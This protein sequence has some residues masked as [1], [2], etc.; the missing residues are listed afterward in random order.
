MPSPT[1]A[2]SVGSNADVFRNIIDYRLDKKKE[3]LDYLMAQEALR[4]D[5]AIIKQQWELLRVQYQRLT[6]MDKDLTD[7]RQGIQSSAA[8][9]LK[10]I[11][12][13]NAQIGA[14]NVRASSEEE[15]LRV[16]AIIDIDKTIEDRD[17]EGRSAVDPLL[18]KAVE[19]GN[20]FVASPGA[21][22]PA[23][24]A[25][26]RLLWDTD[27]ASKYNA[28]KDPVA[29]ARFQKSWYDHVAQMKA[30]AAVNNPGVLS[31]GR[32]TVQDARDAS[33]LPYIDEGTIAE[34]KEKSKD[35][36]N[37]EIYM[38]GYDP[39]EGISAPTFAQRAG[40]PNDKKSV[41]Q[42]YKRAFEGRIKVEHPSWYDETGTLKWEKAEQFEALRND[43]SALEIF[44]QS[45]PDTEKLFLLDS[46]NIDKELQRRKLQIAL[47]ESSRKLR[48]G[49]KRTSFAD[50]ENQAVI[51]YNRLYG[52]R[53][54]KE[55]I[56]Q[57]SRA[58]ELVQGTDLSQDVIFGNVLSRAVEM[59]AAGTPLSPSFM[60][61]L[62][63][64]VRAGEVARQPRNRT[65]DIIPPRPFSSGTIQDMLDNGWAEVRESDGAIVVP[66]TGLVGD[67]VLRVGEVPP[68]PAP[69][70]RALAPAE[71]PAPPN[72]PTGTVT[73]GELEFNTPEDGGAASTG[74]PGSA[75]AG[76]KAASPYDVAA[77]TIGAAVTA[78]AP[79]DRN[80]VLDAYLAVMENPASTEAQRS[81]ASK[82]L[83][84]NIRDSVSSGGDVTPVATPGA[85]VV[86]PIDRNTA[87]NTFLSV[88]DNPK[89]TEAQKS[90][91][92]KALTAHLK[93]SVPSDIETVFGP[94]T[95]SSDR[96]KVLASDIE[97]YAGRK[98]S[99]LTPD[100][101][102]HLDSVA[103]EL[104][105]L[106]SEV[107]KS[108]PSAEV[109]RTLQS[110][111]THAMQL[112]EMDDMNDYSSADAMK[113]IEAG[114]A[115]AK[116]KGHGTLGILKSPDVQK[117]ESIVS[118]IAEGSAKA[119][120]I[121]QESISMDKPVTAS[122]SLPKEKLDA[123][124]IVA[125]APVKSTGKEL[126]STLE[127][128]AGDAWA[129]PSE[130]SKYR[131][132]Y[133]TFSVLG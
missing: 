27:Y 121:Y 10:N 88:M 116:R 62:V 55:L 21:E 44:I 23:F 86:I 104:V 124:K 33:G 57:Y 101:Q 106:H 58:N 3:I 60:K 90:E 6:Q 87:Y 126:D 83:A 123:V 53:K 38:L 41:L 119:A 114:K 71:P 11:V 65:P 26:V 16:G 4:T 109:D 70:I 20:A 29:K 73:T 17:K 50:L 52:T 45:A 92:S 5:P 66:G 34:E 48:E 8:G 69:P 46:T 127:K 76:L 31:S 7:I 78:G 59:S 56:A 103:G 13:G 129:I 80:K 18:D 82:E 100:E 19:A 43:A 75:G 51:E 130:R 84:Q 37:A 28:L 12:A 128:I 89:A 131:Q 95:K 98:Y 99:Q 122:G 96:V 39:A 49:E 107:I 63:R 72:S 32:T 132:W 85:K 115:G 25:S 42:A 67:T 125:T 9:V 40:I 47:D 74:A 22:G 133:T 108:K 105:K 113:A 24:A 68:K 111:G 15:K 36:L 54:Q 79:V 14:A 1:V 118:D 117:K 120:E 93:G 91:A 77:S 102:T 64:E 110:I 97:K 94:Q 112:Q 35:R 30:Q 61:D 81:K 2:P